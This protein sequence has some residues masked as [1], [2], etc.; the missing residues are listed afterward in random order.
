[1]SIPGDT[2]QILTAICRLRRRFAVRKKILYVP[3]QLE[4]DPSVPDLG[5]P[6]GIAILQRHY[7]QPRSQFNKDRP[8]F[9]CLAHEGG[10]NPGLFLKQVAGQWWAVHYEKGACRNLRLPTPT[11]DEQQRQAEYW[12]RAAQDAGWRVDLAHSPTASIRPDALIHG[13]VLTGVEVRQHAM[14]AAGAVDRTAKAAD[15]NVTSVWYSGRAGSPPWAWHVPTVLPRELGIDRPADDELWARL[16]P[17]RT[18]TAAGLRVLRVVKCAVGNIDR[19][20]YGQNWCGRHHP[21]P[22]PWGGLA[23][24]DVAAKMPAG[25]IVPLRFRGVTMPGTRLRDAVFLVSPADFALYEEMTG[26]SGRV[27]YR[28]E[29]GIW[30]VDRQT[31]MWCDSCE[32]RHPVIEHRDCRAAAAA[33]GDDWQG[34][35]PY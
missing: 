5:H 32:S 1:M 33:R 23:V 22:E 30:G 34:W 16:P 14:A 20:P 35:L 28:P 17:R 7:R 11:S 2:I 15:A 18:A 4:L 21:R 27:R 26:W 13:P 10:T 25:E 24:D 6:D 3:D 9:M 19:C 8:A 29:K 31:P 12:A